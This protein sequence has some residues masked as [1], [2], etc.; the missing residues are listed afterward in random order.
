MLITNLI[1]VNKNIFLLA[2]FSLLGGFSFSQTAVRPTSN[3][4]EEPTNRTKEPQE[5]DK[6]ALREKENTAFPVFV[7]TG[8]P[9][10]DNEKYRKTKEA[11]I[12]A[13]PLTY[14]NMISANPKIIYSK[15]EFMT[16]SEDK[17]TEILTHPEKFIVE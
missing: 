7:T 15:T 9:E 6:K 4:V 14:E 3:R 2:F 13:N 17:R 5:I 16:F 12:Q 10:L 8:N 1:S 11:W